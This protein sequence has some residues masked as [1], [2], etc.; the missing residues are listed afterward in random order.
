M[1][2]ALFALLCLVFL[3]TGLTGPARARARRHRLHRVQ[4]VSLPK[5]APLSQQV[6]VADRLVM[7]IS[8]GDQGRTPAQRV[9]AINARLVDIIS[10]EPLLPDRMRLSWR[11]GNEVILVGNHLLTEVTPADARANGATVS[12]LAHLWLSN[13]K[14]TLPQV[15]PVPRPQ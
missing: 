6:V 14:K 10:T 13:L 7:V 15:R 9:D 11:N 3:W 4:S 2:S 5:N 8:A 1:R 12:S